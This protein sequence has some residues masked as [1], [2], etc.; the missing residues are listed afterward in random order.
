[1][2]IDFSPGPFISNQNDKTATLSCSLL[3][4]F[5]KCAANVFTLLILE[6][7]AIDLFWP[8]ESGGE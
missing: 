2:W 6:F 7:S 4:A 1:M 8:V 3:I 5:S